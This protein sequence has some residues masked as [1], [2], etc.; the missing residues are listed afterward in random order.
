MFVGTIHVVTPVDFVDFARGGAGGR[1]FEIAGKTKHGDV[2]RI[3]IEANYHDG[4]GKL[5]AVMYAIAFVAFHIV[6]AGTDGEDVGATVVVGFE[7]FVGGFYEGDE[8]ENVT[9]ATGN[10]GNDVVAP[11]NE[12]SDSDNN[13]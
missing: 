12:P 4:I 3:L 13:K 9:L 5:G 7:A 2:A 11:Q 6:T 10:F 1:S 8:V